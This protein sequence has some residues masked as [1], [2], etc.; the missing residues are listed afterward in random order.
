MKTQEFLESIANQIVAD[1]NLDDAMSTGPSP[2]AEEKEGSVSF[3]V[4]VNLEPFL[5]TI[6]EALNKHDLDRK[7]S[8]TV[9]ALCLHKALKTPMDEALETASAAIE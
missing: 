7:D 3:C 8:V 9:V 5:N 1:F 4:N 6:Q 2:D